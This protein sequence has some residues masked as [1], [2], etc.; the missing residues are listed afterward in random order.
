MQMRFYPMLLTTRG[1]CV[2][3]SEWLNF[4]RLKGSPLVCFGRSLGGAVSLALATRAPHLVRAVVVENT[5]LSISAM[6]DRLMP[7]V[8]SLKGFILNIKWDSDVKVT[9]LKQPILFI[10][11]HIDWSGLILIYFRWSWRISPSKPHGSVA[12][13]SDEQ[14]IQRVLFSSWWNP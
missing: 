7:A 9:S 4:C 12:S 1:V 14:F 2:H 8:S 3:I 13:T 11:G 5:F 10:S 6:V